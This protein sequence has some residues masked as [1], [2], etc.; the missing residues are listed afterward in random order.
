M[1]NVTDPA[2]YD[3][4]QPQAPVTVIVVDTSYNYAELSH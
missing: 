2:V 4:H 3:T 1:P